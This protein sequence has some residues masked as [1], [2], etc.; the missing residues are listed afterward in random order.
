[1]FAQT[2]GEDHKEGDFT[3]TYVSEDKTLMIEPR[4]N[5]MYRLRR[6]DLPSDTIEGDLYTLMNLSEEITNK[7]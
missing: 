3:G 6:W 4:G 5:D 7:L 1:M 2:W